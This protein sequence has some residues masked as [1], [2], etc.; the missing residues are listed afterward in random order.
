M[1]SKACAVFSPMLVLL[2]DLQDSLPQIVERHNVPRLEVRELGELGREGH[3][4]AVPHPPNLPSQRHR[5]ACSPLG[6]HGGVNLSSIL[7]SDNMVDVNPL[8]K[9]PREHSTIGSYPP[10]KSSAP[11]Q[12]RAHLGLSPQQE[13]LT[14]TT[15]KS[16]LVLPVSTTS[17]HF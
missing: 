6:T 5:S 10:S 15:P 7:S 11:C 8:R 17:T 1:R 2:G 16:A 12:D 3:R 4:Q 14:D 9:S 13:K